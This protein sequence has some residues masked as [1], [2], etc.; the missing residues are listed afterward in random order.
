MHSE[1]G[2][3]DGANAHGFFIQTV[4]GVLS[5]RCHPMPK[6]NRDFRWQSGGK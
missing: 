4:F 1:I 6:V 5:V 3:R 2:S